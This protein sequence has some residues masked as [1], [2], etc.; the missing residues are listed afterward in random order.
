MFRNGEL[1]AAIKGAAG[2]GRTGAAASNW[3]NSGVGPDEYYELLENAPKLDY[4]SYHRTHI[5]PIHGIVVMRRDVA[6]EYPWLPEMLYERLTAAKKEY[7]CGLESKA[8]LNAND[9][10]ILRLKSIVDND[11]LPYGIRENK[12]TLEALLY[13]AREQ[14][15]ISKLTVEGLFEDIGE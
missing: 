2:I 6:K 15:I 1:D 7:L 12:E 14:K 10:K 3:E 4:E 9:R 5:Y 13:Y 8:E 11:P